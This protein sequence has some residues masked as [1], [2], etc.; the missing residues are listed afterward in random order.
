[1]NLPSE[2]R[3]F[4]PHSSENLNR[5]GGTRPGTRRKRTITGTRRGYSSHNRGLPTRR[6]RLSFRLA[7]VS[8]RTTPLLKSS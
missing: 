7:L 1:M 2:P 4:G 3:H 5:G 6:L 8:S